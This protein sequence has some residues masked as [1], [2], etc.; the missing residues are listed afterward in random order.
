MSLARVLLPTLPGVLSLLGACDALLTGSGCG[1]GDC[2]L[3]TRVAGQ[4]TDPSGVPV[5]GSDVRLRPLFRGVGHESCVGAPLREEEELDVLVESEGAGEFSAT[6]VAP[7]VDRPSCVE[8]RAEPPS[9]VSLQPT[10]DTIRASWVPP[11]RSIPTSY[12]ALVLPRP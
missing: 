1:A 7:S 12:A 10:T 11:A 5:S 9:G 3:S 2:P 6:L 4:V 8:L